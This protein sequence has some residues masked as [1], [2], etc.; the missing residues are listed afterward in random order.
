LLPSSQHLISPNP[1]IELLH[2][3]S[4]LGGGFSPAGA[5]TGR[6]A[7]IDV[8]RMRKLKGEEIAKSH[9]AS[10]YRAMTVVG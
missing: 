10:V 7:S 1:S 5:Y 3:V 2:F 6:P 9:R 8:D 4:P